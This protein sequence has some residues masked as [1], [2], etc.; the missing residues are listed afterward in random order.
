MTEVEKNTEDDGI[1]FGWL[2]MHGRKQDVHKNRRNKHVNKHP[3]T[4]I[5]HV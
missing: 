5:C 2:Q 4:Y 1:C 3:N